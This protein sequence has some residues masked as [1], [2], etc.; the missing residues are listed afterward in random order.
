MCPQVTMLNRHEELRRRAEALPQEVKE[1]IVRCEKLIDYN[2]HFS[3]LQDLGVLMDGYDNRLQTLLKELKPANGFAVFQ[4]KAAELVEAIIE[5]QRAW[6]FFR[7]KLELRFSP[8]FK[9][10][11]AVADTVAWNCHR[12]VLDLAADEGILDRT[13]LRSPPLTYLGAE[14]S[15]LTWMR[16]TRPYDG[17]I[18]PLGK[19]LTPIPVIELP[20]DHVE[21]LWEFLSIH[22]EAAHDLEADLKLRQPLEKELN[23]QLASEGVDH[24]RIRTWYAWVGEVFADLVALQLGGPAYIEMLLHL[25]LGPADKVIATDATDPHPTRYLRIRM[26]TA[27]ALTL[28][29][30]HPV[31]VPH[32]NQ[33]ETRWKALYGQQPQFNPYIADFPHVFKAL[34]DTPLEELKNKT[35]K[36]LI[37]YTQ[38]DDWRIRYAADYLGTGQNTPE[39]GT[40]AP[41]FCISAARLAV[42][43]AAA[44]DAKGLSERLQ[45]INDRT[46]KL[47]RDNTPGG[48]RAGGMSPRRKKLIAGFA[49][50][51]GK[52][53]APRKE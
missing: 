47:V 52:A 28:L 7:D 33:I 44:G 45:D 34:M 20:W 50:T 48:L 11:L 27:Y 51:F 21:N 53:I 43:K 35:I 13:L 10:P 37:P 12:P 42:T 19:S 1:W 18:H 8:T 39:K 38:T 49:N 4:N 30:N 6:D 41:R 46:Y 24:K 2:A 16:G 22:H 36:S 23:F 40:I 26:N 3:Q 9:K 29:P 17:R 5:A 32:V 31:L 14:F 25:L 15:P